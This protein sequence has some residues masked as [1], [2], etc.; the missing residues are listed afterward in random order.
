MDVGA[1][2]HGL[3][4]GQY[5]A[6]FR[7]NDV[8]ASVLADLTAEDL[9]EMGVASLGHRRKLLVALAT[10]RANALPAA[11]PTRQAITSDPPAAERRQ[12]TVLFCDLVGSTA[13]SAR[14][15]PEDFGVMINAYHRVVSD[16]VRRQG[17]YV[18]KL[19][20]DGVLAYFG[21][22]EAHEDDAERAM[23]A[24]LAATQAVS[25]LEAPEGGRLAARVGLATGPVVVGEVLGEGDARERGVVGETPNLAARLQAVAEPGAVVLDDATRR[26][27]GA[28]FAWADLGGVAL[29]GV[30]GPVRAWQ[31]LGESGV[32]SRFEALRTGHATPLIG[33]EEELEL[34]LRRWRRA[35]AGDGQVVLLRGE[36]GIG[37]S[38]LAAALREA[39]VGDDHDELVLDCSPQH[40]DS[41]L[42]PVA[43]RLER[44]AGLSPGDRPEARLAK[45]E[46][47]LLPLDPPPEDVTLLAELLSVPTVGRW[48]VLDLA[49]QRRRQR[50]LQALL[51]RVR[52]LAARRPVLL[53]VEDAHWIDPSTREL[54]DLLVAEVPRMA[55][56]LVV[57]H[58]PEFDAGAWIGTPHVTPLQLN[59]LA[60]A[61]HLELLHQV[62]GKA[63]PAE[64]EAEVLMRTD[65]VPLFVEEMAKAVLEGGLLREEAEHWVVAGPLPPLAV[66]DTLQASLV[67]RLD[68]L[69]SVREVAQV[70]AVLGREFAYGLLAAVAAV[71]EP[72]LR[73]AL[74]KLEGAG[75][76]HRRGAPPDA[77]YAF[78]HALI[79]D[80]AHATLLRGRRRELH[81]RA[82]TVLEERFPDLAEQQPELLA[83]HYTGAGLLDQAIAYR[84]AAGRRA[85]ARSAA[86]EAVAHY[87]KALDLL[88]GQPA[89]SG[90][91]RTEFDLQVALGAAFVLSKGP[92]VP[93]VGKAYGRAWKLCEGQMESPPL[94]AALAGL[95]NF[96]LHAIGVDAALVV[97]MEMLDKA[98]RLGDTAAQAAGHRC[99]GT[100]FLF[101]GRPSQAQA[102]YKRALAL[103]EGADRASAVFLS[104]SDLRV[105][106]LNFMPLVQ[107]LQGYPDCALARSREG[108]SAAYELGHAYSLSHALHLSCWLHQIRGESWA[109]RERT[110]AM[111][112]LTAEH[113]F[114][115]WSATAEMFHG[116]ALAAGEAGKGAMAEGIARMRRFLA[117]EHDRGKQ[118]L[119][120]YVLGLLA[121]ALT[122]A[123]EPAEALGLI[124]EALARQDGFGVGWYEAEL[125][126]LRGEAVLALASGR[127]AEAEAS[128][129]RALAVAR[130]QGARH[131]ELRAATS[132]A[133]LWAEH[134]EQGKARDLLAPVFDWF[135]EGLETPVLKEARALLNALR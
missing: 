34:L 98:E 22:P 115:N 134:G 124:D 83:H 15:D 85:V 110:S 73:E 31:A 128:Y 111:V 88:A 81:A 57:T 52:S 70:G 65:G 18:A 112:P 117:I 50:L 77:V 54:L 45:L 29:K 28:L 103:Y 68:R 2:L 36:A 78:K 135:S 58:R 33:R 76:L 5:E 79:Q 20:G 1:W 127:A 119:V 80:A 94:L 55:L 62:V 93:E 67:A 129:H 122:Q 14:L 133:R 13:L 4:L 96:R 63:L 49:P 105:A 41:A 47:L 74:A 116:W 71:P 16:A 125:H 46:V 60:P 8:D 109:V 23:R 42:R 82:A 44:A 114:S 99:M 104:A 126:R 39:T 37:K 100:G 102:E 91:D 72:T 87:T 123:G 40:T 120:P 132:L 17:G 113:G 48:P 106:C 30:P 38:R 64:V 118:L 89:G 24:G 107:Q 59:R 43:A 7:D 3:G 27:A 10:L 130:E 56:L 97:A 25:R 61:E 19:L 66:P 75:L 101:R 90:R 35:R 12:L 95:F 92:A 21:W 121:G 53:V 26:L 84:Q 108:L 11:P 9:R 51:R 6:V 86:A 32:E 131:W 69:S